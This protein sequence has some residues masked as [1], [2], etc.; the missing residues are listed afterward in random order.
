MYF[1]TVEAGGWLT[2]VEM[3]PLRIKRFRL[4]RASAEEATWLQQT[5]DRE[6]AKFG[7]RI[8]LSCHGLELVWDRFYGRKAS[9]L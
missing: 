4:N 6:T 9:L 7:A 5:L 3:V 1:V 2:G 8:E